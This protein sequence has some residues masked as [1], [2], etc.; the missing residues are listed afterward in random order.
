MRVR[1][2]KLVII[3]AL[4][5]ATW[6]MH[7]VAQ[8]PSIQ[9]QKQALELRK[10]QIQEEIEVANTILSQTRASRN[11]TLSE[12][13]A[14]DNKLRARQ[15]LINTVQSQVRLSER[16][17][18]NIRAEIRALDD[19]IELLKSKLA[20]ML[21]EAQ[22]RPDD[23]SALRYI[24]ASESFNQAMRRMYYLRQISNFRAQQVEDIKKLQAQKADKI[25]ELE[26]EQGR[27]RQ[28]LA[29]E[30]AHK[31][32]LVTER[33]EREI[34]VNKLKSKEAEITRDISKKRNELDKLEQQIQRII[35]DELRRQREAARAKHAAANG[36]VV[37]NSEDFA[38]TPEGR[39]LAD[40]FASNKGKL[41]WP[42]A[43]GIVTQKF[44]PNKVPGTTGVTINNPGVD[45][46][47][48]TNTEV[49]VVFEGEVSTVVRIPGAGRVVLVRHGNYFTVYS[50]LADVFV[51]PGDKL[52]TKE[53]IGTVASDA[54]SGASVLHFELWKD[55]DNMNPQPW[56]ANS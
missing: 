22:R 42:V 5:V 34:V 7:A 56:L 15:K 46:S 32:E 8:Q 3:L 11:T 47:T 31:Q 53:V 24:L 20:G 21:K 1:N 25:I 50:N 36:G 29:Q 13:R 23:Q 2:S 14:L 4:W 28:L 45:I 35:R 38:L 41:P 37:D 40:N 54:E 49:R 48:P 27:K 39:A 6:S 55:T 16:E 52:D 12:V 43:R 9:E 51:S 44:G 17:I 18:A 30:L 26:A 10:S 33:T 19:E